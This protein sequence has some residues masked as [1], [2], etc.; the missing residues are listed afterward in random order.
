MGTP[1]YRYRAMMDRMRCRSVKA[2]AAVV[3]HEM[4]YSIGDIWVGRLGLL[5]LVLL[6]IRT[7]LVYRAAGRFPIRFHDTA[8]AHGFN[9]TAMSVTFLAFMLNLLLMRAPNWLSLPPSHPWS[10]IYAYTVPLS[11]MEVD[12][13]RLA[14]LVLACLGL[15][16]SAIAQHQMG[17]SWRYG[18]DTGQKTD[19]VT[20]G[21]FRSARHPI[22]FGF[23]LV[24]AGL[25][26]AMPTALTFAA[27]VVLAV[28]LSIQTRLEEEFMR[29][30]H[31][32][33]YKAYYDR[34][35]RWI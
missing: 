11:A 19:L 27:L 26:L 10:D 28:V 32:E 25:F 33:I 31:G 14:G 7:L 29:A 18:L 6:A 16:I 21:L 22:Y 3:E 4:G 30:T 13:V 8:T 20:T 5:I 1:L 17:R 23:L 2:V 15:I 35:R 9:L 12:Q 24:G 34:T